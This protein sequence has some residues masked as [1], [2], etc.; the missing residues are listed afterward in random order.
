[1]NGVRRF[2][3]GGTA[4]T[5][6]SQQFPLPPDSPAASPLPPPPATAPL[7]FPGKPSWP[8]SPIQSPPDSPAVS[9]K[10]TTAALFFRKE[11]QKP[12]RGS[13]GS[14]YRAEDDAG[15]SSY[16]SSQSPRS[17]IGIV[18]PSRSQAS[19]SPIAGPSSP[20]ALPQRV[21]E[22]SRKLPERI[23][24]DVK[25][26]SESF[27]TRDDLLV[28]L[29]ASEAIV[30]SRA[31]EILSAEEVEE[32]KKEHQVLASRLVAI[33][34]KLSLETKIRDAAASL[35]KANASYKNVSKQTSEQ[36]EAANRKVELAQKELWR[37]SERANEIQRRLLEHRAGVLSY[38]VR[39]LEQKANPHAQDGSNGD[40]STSGYSTPNRSSQMSAPPSSITS[41]Q[42][43]SSTGRFDGAHF[44]AGHSDAVV[45]QVPK[46]PLSPTDVSALEEKLKAAT[47]A[48]EAATSRQAETARELAMSQ[49]EKE[50]IE[51]S[52]GMDL[53]AAED[54]IAA[55]ERE[56]SKVEDM[57]AQLHELEAEKEGWMQERVE[58]E[59]RRREVDTLERRL[60][61]LEERSGETNEIKNLL[62]RERE[63]SKVLLEE[64]EREIEEMK[65]M[66][67]ADRDAWLLEKGALQDDAESKTQLTECSGAL[68]DLM[69]T[70]EIPLSSRDGSHLGLVLSI[71]KHMDDQRIKLNMTTQVQQEWSSIRAKLEDDIRVSLDKH[72]ALSV[73]LEETFRARKEV[74][75]QLGELE[76][77]LVDTQRAREEAMIEVAELEA[78]LE[79]T[80]RAGE[81]ARIHVRE[82]EAQLKEQALVQ[83]T[84]ASMQ[85]SAQPQTVVEYKADASA[86]VEM[87]R[88]LWAVLPS[89]EARASRLGS[90][91]FRPASPSSSPI[92]GR[93]QQS[94]SEMDVRSLKTLYDPKSAPLGTVGGN[95]TVEGF[96]GRVQALVTD[97]RA[98][99]E[100][101][102]RFAQAHDLLKKNAERAQKLAQ[103][104]NAA[105]ETYHK[106]V[107]TL[108]DRNM[109]L[110]SRH[111]ALQD[112]VDYLQDSVDRIMAEKLEIETQAEEQAETCRQ[113]SDANNTLSARALNLASEAA[114]ASDS[115]RKQMESQLA[116]TN[117]SLA[118]AKEEIEAMHRSQQTQQMALMEELNS[119]QTENA[120]LRAQLRKK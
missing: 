105:L 4:S 15:N 99:I 95:F 3:A 40:S 83:I 5:P 103:D 22:L 26:A 8:S 34:K 65:L 88:P 68:R 6:T 35:S 87:L 1:M 119:M 53:Q 98:L 70:Y 10:T 60:E 72:Q 107:K 75:I 39:S 25:R 46:L 78:Q 101:L 13:T 85:T 110:L 52:L 33:T 9:P 100:R 23:E 31:C 120:N 79:Q 80:R 27:S 37:V 43:T 67:D 30:D 47:N 14:T 41:I 32:L 117:A 90:R 73:E 115:V 69:S 114:S 109:A 104:S 55:L 45:P 118:E 74:T 54:T 93:S 106:Q 57:E 29:L 112:E 42:T 36:F 21:S 28:S 102:L 18:S 62:A 97:D 48:L 50:Q 108:E 56:I 76:A 24:V 11:K 16:R 20:R 92:A 71:R 12:P 82:L 111:S 63:Q 66:W 2:L 17:S 96:V 58:L 38:S 19:S 89:A 44:F 84:A 51:T 59:E 113:L 116:E 7:F 94:L 64:K 81:E 49:L 86:I 77:Q 91:N 61:V